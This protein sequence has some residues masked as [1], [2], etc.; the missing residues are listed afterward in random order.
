MLIRRLA[1]P[2]D[3]AAVVRDPRTL[4]GNGYVFGFSP[5]QVSRASS[6][7]GSRGPSGSRRVFAPTDGLD[8]EVADDGRGRGVGVSAVI[9]ACER[10]ALPLLVPAPELNR[11]GAAEAS[12][13]RAARVAKPYT[14]MASAHTRPSVA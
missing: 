9:E 7:A 11:Y 10:N 6:R 5:L 2:V 13:L 8:V 12:A 3:P 4:T 14:T 1:S